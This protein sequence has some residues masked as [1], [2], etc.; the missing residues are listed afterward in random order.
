MVGKIISYM[1][2]LFTRKRGSRNEDN[3]HNV[4][5]INKNTYEVHYRIKGRRYTMVVVPERGPPK[6]SSIKGKDGTDL[7]ESLLPYLGPNYNWNHHY[8]SPY[9]HLEEHIEG[10][11]GYIEIEKNTGEKETIYFSSL[12]K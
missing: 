1:K 8:D 10:C 4:K 5:K 7:T 6:V 12:N 11:E 9:E 2:Y 3:S